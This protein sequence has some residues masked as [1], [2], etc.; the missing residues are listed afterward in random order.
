MRPRALQHRKPPVTRASLVFPS[1]RGVPWWQH[2]N[3]DSAVPGRW[4]YGLENV[5]RPGLSVR[6]DELPSSRLGLVRRWGRPRVDV[7]F[8]WDENVGAK[9]VHYPARAR[10]CG[11]IWITDRPIDHPDSARLRSRLNCMDALW[12]L[13]RPQVEALSTWLGPEHPPISFIAFGVDPNFYREQPYPTRPKVLSIGGDRDRDVTTLLETL[14]IVHEERPDA[15]L[16]VQTKHDVKAPE[17]VAVVPFIPH[18][19]VVGELGTASV[20]A[21]ATR[22]NQHAS[23]STVSMEAASVGRPVVITNSPGIEDYVLHGKTGVVVD[24]RDPHQLA[25][26]ILELL[27]DPGKAAAMGR[28]GRELVTGTLNTQNLADSIAKFVLTVAAD[29]SR[30]R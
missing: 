20:V 12:V 21:I 29:H 19:K 27:D 9:L 14:R 22:P 30:T 1:G 8:S 5:E 17:G 7:A 13:S 3:A 28:A 11:V 16:L 15:E 6:P 2:R 24:S 25:G 26:P 4:P 18:A 10:A 23:G